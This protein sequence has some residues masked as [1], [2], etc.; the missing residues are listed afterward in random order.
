MVLARKTTGDMHIG[1]YWYGR[2]F[3][4]QPHGAM[5]QPINV[6]LHGF[7]DWQFFK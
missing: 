1:I 2:I 6:A 4:L 3:H 7:C 5:L